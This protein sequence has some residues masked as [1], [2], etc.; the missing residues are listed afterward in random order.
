MYL[1][2]VLTAFHTAQDNAATVMSNDLRDKEAIDAIRDTDLI[3]MVNIPELVQTN[4]DIAE[5]NIDIYVEANEKCVDDIDNKYLAYV[6]KAEEDIANLESNGKTLSTVLDT[7]SA[8][9][10]EID[11]LKNSDGTSIKESAETE[12]NNTLTQMSANENANIIWTESAFGT[13]NTDADNAINTLNSELEKINNNQALE[14]SEIL[15]S[16]C[17]DMTE[18]LPMMVVIRNEDGTYSLTY[19]SNKQE[20]SQNMSSDDVVK[21]YDNDIPV[22]TISIQDK[23]DNTSVVHARQELMLIIIRKMSEYNDENSVVATA[24]DVIGVNGSMTI[25]EII[26]ECDMDIVVQG[27]LKTLGMNSVSEFLDTADNITVDDISGES[28]IAIDGN[29]ETFREYSILKI[30]AVPTDYSLNVVDTPN[31]MLQLKMLKSNSSGMK[32]QVNNLTLMNTETVK[33]VFDK[34]YVASMEASAARLIEDNKTRYQKELDSIRTYSDQIE[35]FKPDYDSSF[36][37]ENIGLMVDNNAQIVTAVSENNAL[38]MKYANQVYADTSE[39]T[40]ALQNSIMEADK[41]SEEIISSGLATAKAIKEETSLQNQELLLGFS[42]L[43]PYTRLGSVEYT[44]AYKFITDPVELLGNEVAAPINQKIDTTK[45]VSKEDVKLT[46]KSDK[47]GKVIRNIVIGMLA[48]VIIIVVIMVSI[49]KKK[50]A[51]D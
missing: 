7:L 45:D 11:I 16:Y 48:I 12:L 25:N 3:A 8:E 29:L 9:V 32:E 33:S 10:S 49:K 51:W 24:T 27:Y 23:V 13:I 28:E 2:N 6:K 21:E 20:D 31:T 22:L 41:K 26:N 35:A 42:G 38:Y 43:L 40:I 30:K 37:S 4:P 44:Q 47:A 39:N 1:D 36:I 15:A 46:K 17:E 34:S 50:H 5:L 19:E 14:L 18:C